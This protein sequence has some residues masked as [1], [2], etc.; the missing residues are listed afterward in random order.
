[1]RLFTIIFVSFLSAALAESIDIQVLYPE[2]PHENGSHNSSFIAVSDIEETHA[3]LPALASAVGKYIDIQQLLDENAVDPT[4]IFRFSPDY[5]EVQ[6]GDTLRFLNSLGKHT[7]LSIDSMM[8]DGTESFAISHK[9][10]A[11]VTFDVAGIYGIRCK[12]HT[13]YGMVMLVK[14]GDDTSN[15]E[16]AKQIKISKRARLKFD[17]LFKKLEASLKVQG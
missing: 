7:V 1:M 6:P 11:E 3:N 5:V 13:R 12:V 8:P 10:V 17:R 16:E 15:L 4:E 14:V 9:K 2:Q